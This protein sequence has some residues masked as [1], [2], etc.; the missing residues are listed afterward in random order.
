MSDCQ[1]LRV[2]VVHKY[3]VSG[4]HGTLTWKRDYRE[5][6]VTKGDG[7]IGSTG[8]GCKLTALKCGYSCQH[9]S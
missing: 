9:I 4:I 3:E 1:L 6:D 8:K 2:Y 7:R 5:T